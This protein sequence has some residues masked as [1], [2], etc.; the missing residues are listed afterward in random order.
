MTLNHGSVL[1]LTWWNL[2][3]KPDEITRERLLTIS[4]SVPYRFLSPKHAHFGKDSDSHQGDP[5]LDSA[6]QIKSRRN[7]SAEQTE[8]AR[9]RT[10]LNLTQLTHV[11][12]FSSLHSTNSMASS[13]SPPILFISRQLKSGSQTY[14]GLGFVCCLC[15]SF[16]LMPGSKVVNCHCVGSAETTREP[17]EVTSPGHI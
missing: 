15:L 10:S 1:P 3:C 8:E 11:F 9:T 7:T 4:R 5:A 12:L 2:E 17:R 6:E 16:Y 14:W 13:L